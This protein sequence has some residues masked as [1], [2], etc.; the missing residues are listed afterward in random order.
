MTCASLGDIIKPKSVR[1]DLLL[2]R[3]ID[4]PNHSCRVGLGIDWE[5]HLGSATDTYYFACRNT[6]LKILES[7]VHR[8]LSFGLQA[9]SKREN[10]WFQSLVMGVSASI[11]LRICSKK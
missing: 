8:S 1:S 11:Q 2:R 9:K 5:S 3:T 6:Q 10:N 4:S 7:L